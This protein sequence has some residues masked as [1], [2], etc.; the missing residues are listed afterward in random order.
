M[1]DGEGL[2]DLQ[3]ADRK[4]LQE[5]V[6]ARREFPGRPP[7]GR[8]GDRIEELARIEPGDDLV[9]VAPDRDFL[10]P[11]APDPID[12]V[13]GVRPVAD[14][15]AQDDDPVESLPADAGQDCRERLV[16]RMD[17]GEDEVARSFYGRSGRARASSARSTRSA[18]VSIDSSVTGTQTDAIL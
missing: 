17:V 7:R 1:A 18:A 16:V 3:G 9:V 6:V 14:E 15:V 5:P 10:P 2:L 12:D 11:D 8:Q 4:C 13:I